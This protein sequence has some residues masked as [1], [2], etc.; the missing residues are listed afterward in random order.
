[1]AIHVEV[2]RPAQ[3]IQPIGSMLGSEH[4]CYL[5]EQASLGG[6]P[7]GEDLHAALA[8]AKRELGTE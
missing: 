1:M 8:V 6:I 2:D 7:I 5:F 3:P 4:L